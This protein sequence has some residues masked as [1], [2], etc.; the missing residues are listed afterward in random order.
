MDIYMRRR[1]VA[2]GGLVAFFIFFVLVVKSCGGDDEP[3]PVTGPTTGATGQ[4]STTLTA[5]EYIARADEICATANRSVAEIDPT[6]TNATQDEFSITRQELRDLQALGP[7]DD[8]GG[9]QRFLSDLSAV[10]DALRA[11]SQATKSGDIAAQDAA[12]LE[13]DTAE[14]DAR[15]QGESAGFSECGQFLDAGEEVPAGGANAESGT[16]TGTVA[17]STDPGTAAPP[18]DSGTA[19]PPADSGTETPPADSGGGITP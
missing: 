9:I 12:Q 1:L 6:D 13:I 11:K 19:T 10:V 16:D 8:N 3:E 7:P 17:P 2:L 4:E 14:V 18:A 5:D 15:E